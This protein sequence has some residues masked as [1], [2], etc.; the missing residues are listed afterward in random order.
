MVLA[1]VEVAG[2]HRVATIQAHSKA[3]AVEPLE[4]GQLPRLQALA[5]IHPS[6]LLLEGLWVGPWEV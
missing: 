3:V 1:G 4:L 6:L 5:A 2:L